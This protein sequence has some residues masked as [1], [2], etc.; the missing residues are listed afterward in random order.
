MFAGARRF[1]RGIQRQQVGLIRDVLDD[2]DLLGDRGHGGNG[3]LH[4]VAR[5]LGIPD[6]LQGHGPR[7]WRAFSAFC[8][9]DALISS[10]P[11]VVSSTDA[12]C[13]LVPCERD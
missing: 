3:L 2:A 10:K 5:R 6:A 4:C 7:S 9:I 13:S 1:D 11:A 8:V 12:A